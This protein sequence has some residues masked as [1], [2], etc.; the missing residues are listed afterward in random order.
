MSSSIIGYM[1]A[2][3]N[4]PNVLLV[5]LSLCD[6]I[7]MDTLSVLDDQTL[8][9][10]HQLDLIFAKNS[11]RSMLYSHIYFLFLRQSKELNDILRAFGRMISVI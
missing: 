7:N 9:Q 10:N 6:P 3:S 5:F 1:A 2:Y 4:S 8:F 11:V